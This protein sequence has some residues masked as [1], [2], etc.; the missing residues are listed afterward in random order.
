M[1]IWVQGSLSPS[2]LRNRP[3]YYPLHSG[4][5]TLIQA[6]VNCSVRGGPGHDTDMDVGRQGHL[7]GNRFS[8]H[9][10]KHI[11][12][13]LSGTQR[14]TCFSSCHQR[15]LSL[16]TQTSEAGSFLGGC[17]WKAKFYRRSPSP[18][19]AQQGWFLHCAES[20]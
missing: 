8:R 16:Q 11:S 2:H 10:H 17:V 3:W 9:L 1:H 13:L 19:M 4:G 5:H 12:A 7:A 15:G 6:I 14:L 18:K 20:P